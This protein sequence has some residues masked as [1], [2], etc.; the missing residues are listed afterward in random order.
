MGAVRSVA[1]LV[2]PRGSG[3][4]RF[5]RF[6]YRLPVLYRADK[7]FQ[8]V[9]DKGFSPFTTLAI[10]NDLVLALPDDHL[11]ASIFEMMANERR[12]R[13][14]LAQFLDIA[15]GCTSL[16]D[17]GASG[18]FFSTI[19]ARSRPSSVIVSV[20][21]DPP[22][23]AVLRQMRERNRGPA[24]E[25]TID[26][27]GIAAERQT[28]KM[29]SNGYGS[30][31]PGTPDVAVVKSYAE[32]NRRPVTEN[33][34]ELVRLSDICIENRIDPDLIK[35]DIEGFEY[36]AITGSQDYLRRVRP[37]IWLE[38]HKDKMRERGQDPMELAD[39]LAGIGYRTKAGRSV[40]EVI[41]DAD[42]NSHVAL[43]AS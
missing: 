24:C 30:A 2:L 31:V 26:P 19:F 12:G 28:V 38:V 37:R 10:S 23:V 16:V 32:K 15:Q 1:N 20:E 9:G 34:V 5:A 17:I 6:L 35:I 13:A 7:S 29:V 22:S 14:E 41:R 39:T 40:V 8:I 21:P 11:A 42:D 43:V 27:R 33:E 25:W 3:V 36:E 4:R 18:G